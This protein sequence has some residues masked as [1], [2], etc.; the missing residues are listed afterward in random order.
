[1]YGDDEVAAV[2]SAFDA[3]GIV[4]DEGSEAPEDTEP[5]Q[6]EDWIV[7]IN[8]ENGDH[9]LVLIHP[10]TGEKTLLTETQVSTEYSNTIT[11]DASGTRIF[12][13][14]ESNN[15]IQIDPD[16]ENEANL[17]SSSPTLNGLMRQISI[18]PDNNKYVATLKNNP[19]EGLIFDTYLMIVSSEAVNFIELCSPT[20][21]KGICTD[22]IKGIDAM[23]WDP[24]SEVLIYDAFNSIEL[25]NG[26]TN[27]YWNINKLYIQ[28]YIESDTVIISNFMQQA[29]GYHLTNPSYARTNSNYVAFDYG[30]IVN[31]YSYVWTYVYDYYNNEL[32][33]IYFNSG[34]W[35]RPSYSPGDDY[36][37]VQT[38]ES[39]VNVAK[40]I[41]ME[42]QATKTDT[43]AIISE[44]ILSPVWF[45]I[46]G[47]LSTQ[48]NT[49]LPQEISL[50]Q[51][52]P[53]PFNPVTQI[54]FE[55]PFDA[56][57]SISIFD[58]SGRKIK[59]LE[60]R[61]LSTGRHSVQWDGTNQFGKHVSA[62][63]YLCRLETNRFSKTRKIVLLK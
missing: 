3:V 1:L 45:V 55:I 27:D 60:N 46:E 54:D 53:N 31:D 16:G 44:N 32:V 12:F 36:L 8:D 57:V 51:N 49:S 58:I 37:I 25:E 19:A 4:G 10:E 5:V 47:P 61:R 40:T 18:A 15:L 34:V 50:Y 7:A 39:G 56:Q 26:S 9:S 22:D 13:I 20:L 6:G 30:T 14:D 42:N 28:T 21:T 38:S 52:Y 63:V 48:Y 41:V 2:T 17:T 24:S 23:S 43:I 62:G 33:E 35:S 29:E 59:T 11:V